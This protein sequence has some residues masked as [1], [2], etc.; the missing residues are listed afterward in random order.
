MSETIRPDFILR[1][2]RL[3]DTLTLAWRSESS[4]LATLDCGGLRAEVSVYLPD[5][6]QDLAAKL[7]SSADQWRGWP[8][9][10][11][12]A[13]VEGEL[14]I[15]WTH[16]GRGHV[17]FVAALMPPRSKWTSSVVIVVEA[18]Q[19]DR[20]AASAETFFAAY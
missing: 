3:T 14:T 20:L 4:G 18:G 12:W 8:G 5:G 15:T 11:E 7:R 9:E 10:F 1:S 17:S 19:L 16:D 13:S 2:S 6:S